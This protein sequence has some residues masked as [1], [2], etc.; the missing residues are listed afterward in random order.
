MFEVNQELIDIIWL[1]AMVE[2]QSLAGISGFTFNEQVFTNFG[3]LVSNS[4][5]KDLAVVN[6]FIGDFESETA[7]N[8]FL[9]K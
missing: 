4:F 1:T 8:E 2:L 3:E 5:Y 9:A 7:L 6:H